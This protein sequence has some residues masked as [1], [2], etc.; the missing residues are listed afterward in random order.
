MTCGVKAP[1]AAEWARRQEG[2]LLGR[3]EHHAVIYAVRPESRAAV[4]RLQRRGEVVAWPD[5]M[6]PGV[7]A[8]RR[9]GA[10]VRPSGG[11]S[12]A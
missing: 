2:F 5:T 9:R 11:G 3:L 8:V 1:S 10:V 12:A 6:W 7:L 4:E